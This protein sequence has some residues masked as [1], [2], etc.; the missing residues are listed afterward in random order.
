MTSKD[1]AREYLYNYLDIHEPKISKLIRKVHDN[2]IPYHAAWCCRIASRRSEKISSSAMNM[3]HEAIKKVEAEE[4]SENFKLDKPSIQDRVKDKLDDLIGNIE[5][6]IDMDEPFSLYDWL[7]KMEIPRVYTVKIGKYYGPVLKELTEAL[8]NPKVAEGYRHWSKSKLK[9]RIAF[10][11]QLLM[12]AERYSDNTKKVRVPRKK[13]TPSVDKQLKNL[14]YQKDSNEYK[15]TSINPV[16]VIGAQTLWTFNTK[17][18]VLC[19]FN[20][21]GKSGLGIK[22]T[23]LIGYDETTSKSIKIGRK[24]AEK[25]DIVLKGG[26]IAQRKFIDEMDGQ[27]NHRINENTIL[28][29]S[30]KI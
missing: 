1:E 17:Y 29:K 13:K 27:P 22:G 19:V 3:I 26:K 10:Y 8:T 16:S 30:I 6:L 2:W 4:N 28:L 11:D 25:L 12:D 5:E 15:L 23:T 24:T 9:E 14:K 18:N 21:S 20:A 7:T